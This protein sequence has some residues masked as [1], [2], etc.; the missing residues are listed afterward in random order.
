MVPVKK[1]SKCKKRQ[2]RSHLA[3]TPANLTACPK[4]SKA[5]LPHGACSSC[6][7][8]SGKLM[9]ALPGEEG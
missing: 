5:K 3:R 4:C 8:V 7:Y 2:R 9:L 1:T 6:G